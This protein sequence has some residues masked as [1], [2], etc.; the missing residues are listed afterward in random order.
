MSLLY[1]LIYLIEESLKI[2][3]N[4]NFVAY[5]AKTLFGP[6]YHTRGKKRLLKF[7]NV[8]N[9]DSNTFRIEN[10]QDTYERVGL[11]SI[12]NPSFAFMSH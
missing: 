10:P 6:F 8:R 2:A 7:T 9:E 12:P 4:V 5:I 11:F 3:E 1:Q